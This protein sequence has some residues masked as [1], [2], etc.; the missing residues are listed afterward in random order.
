MVC[1]SGGASP[2]LAAF[3]AA[4]HVQCRV[5]GEGADTSSH[6]GREVGAGSQ[7]RWKTKKSAIFTTW[8]VSRLPAKSARNLN[9]Q[10]QSKIQNTIRIKAAILV[11][12]MC[13]GF[14]CLGKSWTTGKNL[15]LGCYWSKAPR[16]RQ[17]GRFV[18]PWNK[19]V[20]I[21]EYPPPKKGSTSG[22]G[23]ALFPIFITR[24]E[25]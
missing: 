13:G 8:S 10:G 12:K 18:R 11:V 1:I 4:P 21:E 22:E 2:Q 7:S 23:R 15:L 9:P 19:K 20:K 25:R 6:V 24:P 14:P 17:C 16:S 3:V 5:C